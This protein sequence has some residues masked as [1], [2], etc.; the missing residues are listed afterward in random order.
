MGFSRPVEK[1]ATF[2][3]PFYAFSFLALQKSQLAC[4][5]SLSPLSLLLFVSLFSEHSLAF[6]PSVSSLSLAVSLF[7]MESLGVAAAAASADSC[8]MSEDALGTSELDLYRNFLCGYVNSVLSRGGDG[9]NNELQ[10]AN[11]VELRGQLSIV[12]YHELKLNDIEGEVYD[13][14]SLHLQ[15]K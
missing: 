8:S 15:Q 12:G 7:A 14:I 2:R 9:T 4:S 5:F 1:E 6:S 13:W 10:S 3:F 11:P